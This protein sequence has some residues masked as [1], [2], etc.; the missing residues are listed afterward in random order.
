MLVLLISVAFE[1]IG[2]T[3]ELLSF[4]DGALEEGFGDSLLNSGTISDVV[5]D[6]DGAV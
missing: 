2:A 3:F 6:F 1:I 5:I 4:F